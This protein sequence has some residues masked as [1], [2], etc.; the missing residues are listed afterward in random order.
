[1]SLKQ[2]LSHT[3]EFMPD[4]WTLEK[5]LAFHEAVPRGLVRF[6]DLSW[7]GGSLAKNLLFVVL[8]QLL[9][10]EILL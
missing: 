10:T 8:L 6:R 7:R 1:M 9:R 3:F 5:Y 4:R 2:N